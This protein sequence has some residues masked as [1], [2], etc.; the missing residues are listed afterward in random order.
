MALLT[1][2]TRQRIETARI[3]RNMRRRLALSQRVR[4]EQQAFEQLP[5]DIETDI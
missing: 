2:A 3:A 1:R 4:A 5:V